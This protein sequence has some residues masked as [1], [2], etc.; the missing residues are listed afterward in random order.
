MWSLK[1]G[2]HFREVLLTEG[3]CLRE[4]VTLERF[5]LQKVAA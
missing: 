5:Y 2:G 1:G 4:V 3:G